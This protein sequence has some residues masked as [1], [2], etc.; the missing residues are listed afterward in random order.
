MVFVYNVE[1]VGDV[2]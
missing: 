1:H 2:A